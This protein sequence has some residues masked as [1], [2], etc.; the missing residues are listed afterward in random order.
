MKLLST[1]AVDGSIVS[2]PF[3]YLRFDATNVVEPSGVVGN[4]TFREAGFVNLPVLRSLD[5][6]DL[7]KLVEWDL[8]GCSFV[9]GSHLVDGFQRLLI[10]ALPKDFDERYSLG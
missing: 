6:I 9:I 7:A 1:S 3:C 8:S 10:V 4:S 2:N 5:R